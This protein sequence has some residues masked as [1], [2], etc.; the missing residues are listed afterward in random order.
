MFRCCLELRDIRKLY[1]NAHVDHLFVVI[2]EIQFASRA[3]TFFLV[4]SGVVQAC[5]DISADFDVKR[6]D[7]I[8]ALGRISLEQDNI[9]L[10]TALS[11]VLHTV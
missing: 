10:L 7:S 3:G 8:I 6:F 2:I 4:T 1:I 5:T 9:C 11:Y